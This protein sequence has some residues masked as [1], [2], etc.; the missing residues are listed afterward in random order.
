M[1]MDLLSQLST[2]I[3][4]PLIPPFN[5]RRESLFAHPFSLGQIP[6]KRHHSASVSV[7]PVQD[8]IRGEGYEGRT[9]NPFGNMTEA[10]NKK[11][12]D[13]SNLMSG[14]W[15]SFVVDRD[16]NGHSV[17]G[18]KQWPVY[19]SSLEAGWALIWYLRL[20]LQS[21]VLSGI[22]GGEKASISLM[23]TG[24]EFMGCDEVKVC[25]SLVILKYLIPIRRPFVDC[26]R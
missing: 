22:V 5:F 25:H 4:S 14:S 20:I 24:W 6:M 8:N 2:M 13:L 15:V 16:P 21:S 23:R 17:E 10:D 18:V 7:L 3:S 12:V 9:A 26:N 1:D 11:F 19:N